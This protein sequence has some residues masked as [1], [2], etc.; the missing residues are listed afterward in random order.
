MAI[1]KDTLDD[2]LACRDPNPLVVFDAIRVKIRDEGLVRDKAVY[3]AL[4]GRNRS[5]L[6][7]R[8]RGFAIR[9]ISRR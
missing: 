9:I 4:G 1:K 2:L 6:L 5:A 8:R 7:R 3:L